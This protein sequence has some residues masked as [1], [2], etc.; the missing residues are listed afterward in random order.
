[1][2]VT[3]QLPVKKASEVVDAQGWNGLIFGHSGAGKTWLASTANDSRFGTPAL[4]CDTEDG[5]RTISDRD[6]L[7]VL[8]KDAITSFARLE[9]V[10][11]VVR[12]EKVYRTVVLDGLFGA[13]DMAYKEQLAA[14]GRPDGPAQIQDWGRTND[15][16]GGLCQD[17]VDMSKRYG[18]NF[19]ATAPATEVVD[20]TSHTVLTRIDLTPGLIKLLFK[21][22]DVVAYLGVQPGTK[23][24]PIGKR[25]LQLYSTHNIIAK[26]RQPMSGPQLPIELEGED[27]CMD[28]L[29]AA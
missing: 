24:N 28:S 20:E 19:I 23:Q 2:S 22:F 13:Y 9:Q 5:I 16:V 14:A 4:F 7:D 6:D 15:R 26:V 27:L 21:C 29:F 8:T 3:T 25:K 10:R 18:I 1:M 17:F 12:Q 11:D